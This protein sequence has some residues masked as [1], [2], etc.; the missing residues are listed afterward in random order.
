MDRRFMIYI[1]SII[2]VGSRESPEVQKSNGLILTLANSR[3][4]LLLILHTFLL[5]RPQAL[6]RVCCRCFYC[7][8]ANSKPRDNFRNKNG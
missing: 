1:N 4:Q 2:N 7:L 5:F 3:V 8:V 6:H